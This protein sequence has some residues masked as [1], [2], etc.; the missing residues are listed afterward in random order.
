[1]ES[2]KINKNF[3][4]DY[5]NEEIYVI[6]DKNDLEKHYLIYLIEILVKIKEMIK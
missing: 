5:K 6:L 4:L 2:Y 3:R 1:M